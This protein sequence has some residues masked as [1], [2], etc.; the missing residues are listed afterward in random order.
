[1]L[2][3]L[4]KCILKGNGVIEKM[5]AVKNSVSMDKNLC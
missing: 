5:E 1:M 4:E 2:N 3:C